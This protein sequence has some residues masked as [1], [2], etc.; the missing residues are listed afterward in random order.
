[1][2]KS[3]IN[4][5]INIYIYIKKNHELN[6]DWSIYYWTISQLIILFLCFVGDSSFGEKHVCGVYPS[7]LKTMADFQ[8]RSTKVTPFCL[9]YIPIYIYILCIY[10]YCTYLC[11]YIY[12]LCISIYFFKCI[13]IL[14]YVYIYSIHIIHK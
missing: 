6:G 5:N 13:Y 12:I 3:I 8:S 1:M 4:G 2:G 9:P 7:N 11:I 14:L 10:I